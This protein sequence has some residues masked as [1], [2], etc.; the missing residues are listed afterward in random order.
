MNLTKERVNGY[1]SALEY[2]TECT[3]ATVVDMAMSSRPKVGEFHRQINIAQNGIAWLAEYGRSERDTCQRVSDVLNNYQGNVKKW[4]Q[5]SR[6]KWH[7]E[8]PIKI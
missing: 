2:M 5:N 7:P 6:D 8:K 4:A 1:A 3:L